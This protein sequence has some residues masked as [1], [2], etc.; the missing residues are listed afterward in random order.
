M[1]IDTNNMISITEANKNFSLVAKMVDEKG[2]MFILKNNSPKYVLLEF[3]SYE[4]ESMYKTASKDDIL[5]LSNFFI[6]KN[7]DA[8]EVLAK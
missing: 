1:N 4:K 2:C 7:K 3:D 5:S 6:D 8:Y